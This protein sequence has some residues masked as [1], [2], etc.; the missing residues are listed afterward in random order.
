MF[1]E[2][3]LLIRKDMGN[4]KSNLNSDNILKSIRGPIHHIVEIL[5]LKYFNFCEKFVKKKTIH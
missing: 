1:L 3:L 5:S 4:P 2:L